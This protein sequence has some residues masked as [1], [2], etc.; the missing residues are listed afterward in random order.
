LAGL[1]IFVTSPPPSTCAFPGPWHPSQVM[2]VF[3]CISAIFVCGFDANPFTASSWQVAHVSCPTYSPAGALADWLF[4]APAGPFAGA[5]AAALEHINAGSSNNRASK[6][7]FISAL[8]WSC[9][10]TTIRSLCIKVTH[11]KLPANLCQLANLRLDAF[12]SR[13][14]A[15][16]EQSACTTRL[17]LC[18]ASPYGRNRN[19]LGTYLTVT[20]ITC[21]LWL[22]RSGRALLC[23]PRLGSG[24]EHRSRATPFTHRICLHSHTTHT[25]SGHQSILPVPESS[26]ARLTSAVDRLHFYASR[27]NSRRPGFFANTTG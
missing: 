2:P 6:Q 1:K 23:Q 25:V 27:H 5:P 24:A 16:V 22:F 20:S 9:L 14:L 11:G 13:N 26:L 4:T 21:G 18:G 19:A 7:S 8:A 17:R 3:P 10:P 12:L 15:E